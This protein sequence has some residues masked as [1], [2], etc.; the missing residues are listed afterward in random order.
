M[1]TSA[2]ISIL[3]PAPVRRRGN[4]C[5]DGRTG[6]RDGGGG[7][8]GGR[9]RDGGGVRRIYHLS[10]MPTV[11]SVSAGLGGCLRN[12]LGIRCGISALW[13]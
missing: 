7:P 11:F 4:G 2:M 1:P 6:R 5:G 12:A 10:S 9:G 3:T 13:A 8:D